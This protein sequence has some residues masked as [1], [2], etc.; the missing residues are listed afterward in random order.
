MF[1]ICRNIHLKS[2]SCNL[3]YVILLKSKSPPNS[4]L[5][6][7]SFSFWF[8]LVYFGAGGGIR[9]HEPLQDRLLK[10]TPLTRL[11][12][13][14]TLDST[15]NWLPVN[16][17]VAEVGADFLL[18]SGYLVPILVLAACLLRPC[19]STSKYALFENNNSLSRDWA[20]DVDWVAGKF[21]RLMQVID[22][23]TWR[24]FCLLE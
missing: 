13:P 16:K 14:C 8:I 23:I 7:F 12:D 18:V 3:Y 20:F 10:P 1:L 22:N 6:N 17:Y 5:P 15:P 24:L 4:Y 19:Q 21:A 11:G 9:T 2:L